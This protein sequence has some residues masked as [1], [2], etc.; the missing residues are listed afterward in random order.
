MP[1][2]WGVGKG[3]CGELPH[4]PQ[5]DVRRGI[6]ATRGRIGGHCF[7]GGSVLLASPS[8]YR[9]TRQNKSCLRRG[10]VSTIRQAGAAGHASPSPS[11]VGGM[12][13]AGHVSRQGLAPPEGSA[14]YYSKTPHGILKAGPKS[15][16]CGWRGSL[17][18]L[19]PDPVR[20]AI[21]PDPFEGRDAT[22]FWKH[23]KPTR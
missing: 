13:G 15:S 18:P 20:A 23:L 4:H 16:R 12:V 5:V 22:R 1:L 2:A 10:H 19:L 8:L 6:V 21:E 9:S 11:G 17:R 3:A 7:P 14:L